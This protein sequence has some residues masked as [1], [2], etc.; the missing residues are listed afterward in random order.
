MNRRILVMALA[1]GLAAFSSA[2]ST[3]DNKGSESFTETDSGKTFATSPGT[4]FDISLKGNYTTGYSWNIVTC[5]KSIL[6]PA[7]SQYT[8]NQPQLTGSGGVQH[9]TF[10]IVG[11]GQTTLKITYHRVWEK[12]VAPA[13]TFTL[14]IDSK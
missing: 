10:N 1:A 2:C 3:R 8:P 13:Q 14:Q 7:G 11:K 4:T 5:D 6:Q 12:D 9:Y